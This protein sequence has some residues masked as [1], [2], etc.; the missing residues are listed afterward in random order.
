MWLM[1]TPA[2]VA[3]QDVSVLVGGVHARYADSVTGT[4]GLVSARF[5][6]SARRTAGVLDASFSRFATGETAI[7]FGGQAVHAWQVSRAASLGFV[8]FGSFG[9]FD[10]GSRSGTVAAG[11][12]LLLGAG[13]VGGSVRFA[14]GAVERVDGA[15]LS[16]LT[17]DARLD[18]R[19]TQALTLTL[20]GNATRA[21][22]VRF[23]D[24]GGEFTLSHGFVRLESGIGVRAGDLRDNPAW[25]VRLSLQAT[26]GTV[27]E[28]STGAYPRDISGFNSGGFA[29][30]GFRVR[31]PAR[32]PA[33]LRRAVAV[34]RLGAERVRVSINF[35]Q[36]REVAIA[37]EWNAWTPAALSRSGG[38]W[39]IDLGLR[40]GV[41]RFSLLVNGDRW[42]V[43]DDVAAVPDDFG[44]KAAL[45]VVPP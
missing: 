10:G 21:D 16:L 4:A 40:P 29:S 30:V 27:F 8:G 12:A 31:V 37:G 7:Q 15:R 11:P 5:G 6:A 2:A 19:I 36:A 18:T 42:T 20:R 1:A 23:A 45:L 13:R 44:G 9:A 34:Q 17:A 35:P 14:G 41:Y 26:P 22:H 39:T 33:P 25:H 43:P 24:L 3:A 32:I 28:A 38:R